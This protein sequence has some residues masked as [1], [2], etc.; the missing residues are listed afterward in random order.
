MIPVAIIDVSENPE[1]A[2]EFGI[3]ALPSLYLMTN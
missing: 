2:K 1:L 3:A